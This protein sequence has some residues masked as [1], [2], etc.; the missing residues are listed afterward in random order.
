MSNAK[1]KGLEFT[2]NQI[3]KALGAIENLIGNPNTPESNRLQFENNYL[4][5]RG[6]TYFY[7]FDISKKSTST[8]KSL[9]YGT[10]D[11]LDIAE[12]TLQG[13][14]IGVSYNLS[15]FLNPVIWDPQYSSPPCPEGWGIYD[16]NAWSKYIPEYNVNN[17]PNNDYII[18]NPYGEPGSG[19]ARSIY[20]FPV[21]W[22]SSGATYERVPYFKYGMFIALYN[23]NSGSSN[24]NSFNLALNKDLFSN[25]ININPSTNCPED[26][27]VYS[28]NNLISDTSIDPITLGGA[29][30]VTSNSDVLDCLSFSI[31]ESD[32]YLISNSNNLD[33]YHFNVELPT[34]YSWEYD[35]LRYFVI[36]WGSHDPFIDTL[37]TSAIGNTNSLTF[38]GFNPNDI[39]TFP[40][41]LFFDKKIGNS[42]YFNKTGINDKNLYFYNKDDI[43]NTFKELVY[44]PISEPFRYELDE[45]ISGSTYGFNNSLIGFNYLNEN[46]L[47]PFIVASKNDG[48]YYDDPKLN[49]EIFVG[50]PIQK[51]EIPSDWEDFTDYPSIPKDYK[52]ICK[53]IASGNSKN[54][55]SWHPDN[56]NQLIND[57]SI[58][59]IKMVADNSLKQPISDSDF[60]EYFIDSFLNYAIKIRSY[61]YRKPLINLGQRL[62]SRFSGYDLNKIRNQGHFSSASSLEYISLHNLLKAPSNENL[63]NLNASEPRNIQ[64]DNDSSKLIGYFATNPPSLNFAGIGTSFLFLNNFK[65]NKDNTFEVYLETNKSI[66]TNGTLKDYAI[67]VKFSN[68]KNQKTIKDIFIN[69]SSFFLTSSEYDK[70]KSK[71]LSTDGYFTASTL[72]NISDYK[73]YGESSVIP[74][75]K[76]G[77]YKIITNKQNAPINSNRL[78]ESQY[79]ELLLAKNPSLTKNQIISAKTGFGLTDSFYI[80]DLTSP[81]NLFSSI[82]EISLST[83]NY[84]YKSNSY[85]VNNTDF[86]YGLGISTDIKNASHIKDLKSDSFIL[87]PVGYMT[88]D[89]TVNLLENI[90]DQQTV[91]SIAST[92]NQL[93]QNNVQSIYEN[94]IAFKIIC[95]ETQNIKSLI[96]KLRKYSDFVNSNSVLTA[97]L[98]SDNNNV[99]FE[100]LAK[101]SQ[102]YL[103]NI[104]NKLNNYI[105]YLDYKLFKNKIY[106]IVLNISQMP[107]KY[108]PYNYG[109]ISVNDSN[110]TGLYNPLNNKYTE[111][112]RYLIGAQLGIGSTNPSLINNWYSI[113]SIASSTSM[114][115]ASTGTTLTKQPYSIR[116]KFEIGVEEEN[117]SGADK[118]IYVYNSGTGWTNIEGTPFI[119]FSAPD[120]QIY[121]T[122]NKDYSNSN[123]IIAPPNRYRSTSNY[124]VDEYWSFN[125]KKIFNPVQMAFYP[126]SVNLSKSEIISSGIAG[127]YFISVKEID[128]ND[129]ILVG[130]G[131][132]QT[133]QFSAGTS[134]TSITYNSTTKTYS[135]KLNKPILTSFTTSKVGIGSNYASY[136]KRA[137]D[138]YVQLSYYKNGG[139]ATS[140]YLLEK[141]PSW[142]TKW[143][144]KNR[145]TYN[146]LT[147][148]SAADLLTSTYDLNFENFKIYENYSYINGFA[149]AN[150]KPLAGIGTSFDFKFICSGGIKV[151]LNDNINASLDYWKTNAATGY[152]FSHSIGTTSEN[153]K[154][155]VQFNKT[156]PSV[157]T[158]IG[159]TLQGYW[160]ISG[161]GTWYP[162]NDTFYID[163]AISPTIIDTELINSIE[164]LKVGRTLVSVTENLPSSDKLVIR[165]S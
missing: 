89:S 57:L 106:W 37:K 35:K 54:R 107:P 59:Y 165:S 22:S 152:S 40:K 5:L 85:W 62:I 53:I 63:L 13:G 78:T 161:T 157:S 104:N 94:K 34:S 38:N 25:C 126:R 114:I 129:K 44:T 148:N 65:L 115:V 29:M 108:D 82:D 147:K 105:F 72:N 66:S 133:S 79:E 96:L 123:L 120:D 50:T 111:F 14:S 158:G 80:E 134:I 7:D 68:S 88:T 32:K 30:G 17:N 113:S 127:S 140:N 81:S 93:I 27:L 52:S 150:F 51:E 98:Y 138:I 73:L 70:R 90:G 116:Y 118:N 141:S 26:L 67:R 137:N 36:Y 23:S 156:A 21:R 83:T 97:D 117:L 2:A 142:I 33:H 146:E 1:R 102:V 56:V 160:K 58:V 154:F 119:K 4:K 163:P 103:K 159:I 47:L 145:F 92:I 12:Y 16:Y 24:I 71:N 55:T 155:E 77:N 3:G 42:L 136:I 18:Y 45:S 164:M 28:H 91:S 86:L 131:I 15:N 48:I 101:S 41:K 74:D 100:I 9:Q 49:L 19:I 121:G 39:I 128:Y 135:L 143:Y 130:L 43:Q 76:F 8:K 20:N 69:A 11:S 153:I 162:L 149:I 87:A 112:T 151:Y 99:P 31:V 122:F 132:S 10:F 110:I 124:V 64:F 139:I 144:V 84:R 95:D 125:N 75:L 6:S 61:D 109:L 46:E 60:V